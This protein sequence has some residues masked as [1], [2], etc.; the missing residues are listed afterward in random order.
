MKNNEEIRKAWRA[1]YG[2]LRNQGLDFF[3]QDEIDTIVVTLAEVMG[4]KR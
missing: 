3:L 2:A 1:I 4:N